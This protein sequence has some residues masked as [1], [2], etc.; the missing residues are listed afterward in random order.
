[1]RT[2]ACLVAVLSVSACNYVPP[3]SP[4]SARATAG[5]VVS[6]DAGWR[7]VDEETGTISDLAGLRSLARAFPDSA[8]VRLRLLRHYAET[9]NAAGVVREALWLADRGYSFSD[10]GR[11]QILNMAGETAIAANLAAAL[12]SNAKPIERSEV[13]ATVPETAKLV[14]G[15]AIDPANGRMVVSTVVSRMI[16]GIDDDGTWTGAPLPNANS[17]S[18][19]AIDPETRTLWV[20]SADLGMSGAEAGTM[21]KG[22]FRFGINQNTSPTSIELVSGGNPSD[23]HLAGGGKVYASNPLGGEIY[24]AAPGQSQ[25]EKIVG[26]DKRQFRSP[27]GLATSADG[28]KLYVSDYRYGIAIVDLHSGKISRLVAQKPVILDG[29]DGLWRAGNRLIGIQNGMN[30]M[31]IV[32]IDLSDDGKSATN[33]TVLEQAHSAWTEPL[34]GTIRDGA[35]YYVATGQWDRFE[36]GGVPIEGKPSIATQVRRLPL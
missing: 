5:F 8:S 15:I 34:G 28:T 36:E 30:P 10:A 22:L 25:L 19:I 4:G 6:G 2:L 13:A 33:L 12:K 14:E 27:Q 3:V 24:L 32:A 26:Q 1:M 9:E 23:I 21:A 7:A 16:F 11:A 18:G 29:I 17:L 31:R 35:L 20:A